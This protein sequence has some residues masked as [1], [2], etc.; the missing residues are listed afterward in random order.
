M[1]FKGNI[2][3]NLI[4][5]PLLLLAAAPCY[6]ANGKQPPPLPAVAISRDADGALVLSGT[7]C[8]T[9]ERQSAALADW[10][11]RLHEEA[12]QPDTCRC[13]ADDC[14]VRIASV[15]PDFVNLMHG[16]KAGRWGPNCWNTALVSDKI[17]TAPSFTSPEE[18]T[19]W[20]GSPLCRALR[21]GELPRPGDIIAIRGQAGEEMH[22]FIYLTEEL[23]FSK[24]YLTAAAPYALQS[25]ADVY[26]EFPVPE[27]CRKPGASAA[28]CAVHSDY[29]RCSALQ[30]YLSSADVSMD[31]DYSGAAAVVADAE[32][33]ISDLILR[34]KTD[35]ELQSRAAEILAAKQKELLPAREL[36]RGRSGLLWNALALRIDSLLHQISLI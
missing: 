6:A 36:A 33:A 23:S 2:N 1:T 7:D 5:L 12:G 11:D 9:L 14:S 27:E 18:M 19:F 25:P 17:L 4:F 8:S 15:A 29:F 28:A 26:A 22:G 31:K 3:I 10:R 24:N 35:P 32:K 13:Q 16:V 34:W 21:A 30:N 20:M